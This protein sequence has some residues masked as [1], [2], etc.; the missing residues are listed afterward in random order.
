MTAAN[1]SRHDLPVL[2]LRRE[3]YVRFDSPRLGLRVWL[4]VIAALIGSFA[5]RQASAP[6]SLSRPAQV[7]IP[8]RS[9]LDP[10]PCV[11]Q[12]NAFRSGVNPPRQVYEVEPDLIGLPKLSKEQFAIIELRIDDSG[13]VAESCLLRGVR[14][15]VDRRALDAVK[16]WRFEPARLRSDVVAGGR[17]FDAGEP[18]PL[19]MTVTVRIG[20][21]P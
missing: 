19:F 18:V 5:C 11:Y 6:D 15:D 2:T 17:R 14:P 3:G 21:K 4:I 13:H 16:R 7:G 9:S 1:R 12:E 20:S 10:P 8:A